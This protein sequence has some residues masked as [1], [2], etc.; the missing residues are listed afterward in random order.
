MRT[1]ER[2]PQGPVLEN[3]V[4]VE[5]KFRPIMF[6]AGLGALFTVLIVYVFV[7]WMTSGNVKP[8]PTGPTPV[9]TWMKVTTHGWEA[10]GL[11]VTVWFLYAFV[12]RPWRREGRIT[13][14]GLLILALATCYWQD[15]MINY[16]QYVCTYNAEFFNWGSWYAQVPGWLPPLGNQFIEAP[17]WA[18][19]AYIYLVFGGVLFGC[20]IMRR[21]KARWPHMGKFGLAM[22]CMGVFVIADLIVE[23]MFLFL[24][25]YTYPGAI[26]WMTLSHG[27]YYQLPLYEAVLFPATVTV[28]TCL[29]HFRNDR[30]QTVAERGSDELP[31]KARQKTVLR[32]LALVGITNALYL[33]FYNIPHSFF[34]LHSSPW[35]EDITSRSYFTNGL[36]G[37][38]TEYACPSPAIPINRPDSVHVSPEG[39]LVVPAGTKL[40]SQG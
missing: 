21:A 22:C 33:A 9:P 3:L 30:G 14:D 5:R 26:S 31:R 36:C 40:P 1:E 15:M 17:V 11:V 18:L 8:T 20:L 29:R 35:P 25:F 2:T 34:A 27:H 23:P 37:P 38:G 39:T 6:W 32:F 7:A 19:P 4:P 16:T 28:W 13:S 12:V 24:G 10:L